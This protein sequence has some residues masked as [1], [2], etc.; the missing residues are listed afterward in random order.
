MIGW[1]MDI[2]ILLSLLFS[3]MLGSLPSAVIV[4]RLAKGVDIRELGD[5][6]MGARNTYRTLGLGAGIAVA[7]ADGCKGALSVLIARW[8]GLTPFWQAGAG[9]TAVLGHDFPIYVKFRGGQGLATVLGT[10]LALFPNQTALG[11]IVYGV[12]YLIT[13]L[14]D[15]SAGIGCGLIFVLHILK[16]NWTFAAFV[17]LMFLTIPLK[18]ALMD[19]QRAEQKSREDVPQEKKATP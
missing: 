17:A 8:L 14:S 7:L 16:R 3:Y 19:H 5:G 13:R 4:S 12:L 10:F 6:N 11:M 15:L 1:E 2:K 9:V 18:K